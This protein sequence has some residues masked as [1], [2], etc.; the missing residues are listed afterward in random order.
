MLT[1]TGAEKKIDVS[2]TQHELIWL[3]QM[4]AMIEFNAHCPDCVSCA[5]ELQEKFLDVLPTKERAIAMKIVM[6]TVM[7]ME[8]RRESDEA[9]H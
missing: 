1:K 5:S 9:Q 8:D 4:M 7:E 3:S 2:L 6:E